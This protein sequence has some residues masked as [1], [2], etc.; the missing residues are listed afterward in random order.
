MALFLHDI[1]D[2][3][4]ER[5]DTLLDPKHLSGEKVLKRFDLVLAQSAVQPEV[6]GATLCGPRVTLTGETSTDARLS[7]MATSRSFSTWSPQ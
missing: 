6:V 3:F 7:R 1:D 4:L 5:G 2:A